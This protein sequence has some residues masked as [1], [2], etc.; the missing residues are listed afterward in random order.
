M[1]VTV[2]GGGVTG[3]ATAAALA[4]HAGVQVTVVAAR[5][6]QCPPNALWECP[7]Y[8]IE[9]AGLACKWAIATFK[10][11]LALSE[12]HPDIAAVKRLYYLIRH[13]DTSTETQETLTSLA[14]HAT[15]DSYI[16]YSACA[17][18]E[19]S[20]ARVL[21]PTRHARFSG[22]HA[23]DSVVVN[24]RAYLSFLEKKAKERGVR[25]VRGHVDSLNA[26]QLRGADVIVVAAGLRSGALVGDE[27][28]VPVRGQVV[29][30]AAPD[31]DVSLADLTTGAYVIPPVSAQEGTLECG[32]TADVGVSSR[33]PSSDDTER[34][35][36]GCRDMIPTLHNVPCEDVWVG[37][38]PSR[39]TGVRVDSSRLPDG[40]LLVCAYGTGGAGY[41]CSFG[42]AHHVVALVVG[43]ARL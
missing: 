43:Q 23:Y 29:H 37:V 33:E 22:A 12:K 16:N 2:V 17:L 39:K 11:F 10:D 14:L 15:R 1:R 5:R 30:V 19:D 41:T 27:D 7:P 34:I 3:L 20:L 25:I 8:K 6:G 42:L 26:E 18:D 13:G 40:R 31:I 9:P 24:T 38:R 28:V 32:G 21:G 4:Q 35:M 36:R